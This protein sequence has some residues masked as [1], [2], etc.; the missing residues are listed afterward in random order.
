[1]EKTTQYR[2]RI[3][4]ILVA[5]AVFITIYGVVDALLKPV[6]MR[7]NQLA[8]V[9]SSAESVTAGEYRDLLGNRHY[10]DLL[11]EVKLTSRQAQDLAAIFRGYVWL[12][13]TG[14]ACLFNPHHQIAC[15]MPDGSAHII[16][17]C[18]ACGDIALDDGPAYDMRGWEPDIRKLLEA[19]GVP[20]RENLYRYEPAK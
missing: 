10:E 4:R 7:G 15:T 19:A 9:L 13:D 14:K 6:K 16:H 12:A 5:L 20:I 1:M 11:T 2:K 17:I 18:F 8:A 3:T